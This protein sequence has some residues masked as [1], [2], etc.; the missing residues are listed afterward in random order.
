MG[1]QRRCLRHATCPPRAKLSMVCRKWLL[2]VVLEAFGNPLTG[3]TSYRRLPH[4]H[5]LRRK[6]L[7]VRRSG[8]SYQDCGMQ[9]RERCINAY[10]NINM[11]HIVDR[12]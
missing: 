7:V 4:T 6:V 3:I 2:R 12:E 11:S 8:G 9:E 10:S 5:R 1:R